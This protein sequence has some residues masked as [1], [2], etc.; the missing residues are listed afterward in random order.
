MNISTEQILH[1]KK[2]DSLLHKFIK[3]QTLACFYFA[4]ALMKMYRCSS[5]VSILEQFLDHL[6]IPH[7]PTTSILLLL[8]TLT[9]SL[10]WHYGIVKN[11]WHVHDT[12]S[13]KVILGILGFQTHCSFLLNDN[14]YSSWRLTEAEPQVNVPAL[15]LWYKYGPPSLKRV[16]CFIMLLVCFTFMVLICNNGH[17]NSNR[18]HQLFSSRQTTSGQ[19]SSVACN[20]LVTLKNAKIR[21]KDE[22]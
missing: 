7:P 15:S 12:I 5:T 10:P 16:C 18:F 2:T 9:N 4:W 3:V 6:D 19:K 14:S 20:H 1:V 22:Q 21:S 17:A 11:L 8:Q 13:V